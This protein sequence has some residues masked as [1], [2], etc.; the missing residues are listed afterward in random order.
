MWIY[1]NIVGEPV[2]VGICV[3][4]GEQHV[5]SWYYPALRDSFDTNRKTAIMFLT[6]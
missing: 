3:F 4:H 2:E 5:T 1:L 6:K